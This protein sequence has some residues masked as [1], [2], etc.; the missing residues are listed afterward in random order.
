MNVT[1]NAMLIACFLLLAHLL[2]H[3]D[4]DDVIRLRVRSV[5]TAM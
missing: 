2:T 1:S 3:A 4:V 5:K